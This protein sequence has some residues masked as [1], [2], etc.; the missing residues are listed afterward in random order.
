MNA[1]TTW[2]IDL[3]ASARSGLDPATHISHFT[4]DV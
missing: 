1:S 2:S 3:P 4:E